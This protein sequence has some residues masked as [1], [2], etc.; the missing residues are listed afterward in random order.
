MGSATAKMRWLHG[1]LGG[2]EGEGRKGE[3]FTS[4]D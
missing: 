2:W 4:P 1:G 3:V